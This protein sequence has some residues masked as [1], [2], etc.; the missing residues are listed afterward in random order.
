MDNKIIYENKPYG[1]TQNSLNTTN[2][3]KPFVNM[4]EIKQEL[5]ISKYATL[6]NDYWKLDGTLSLVPDEPKNIGSMSES[7]SNEN[8]VFDKEITITR[9]YDN[10]YT[11][12]RNN[13]NF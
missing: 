13:D 1:A 7:L 10:T 6:E 2:D 4:D 12:P 3:M 8:G 9:T 5:N 11:S